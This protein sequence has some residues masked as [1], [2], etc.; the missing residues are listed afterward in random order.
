MCDNLSYVFMF[1]SI[2]TSNMVATVKEGHA[3]E[4]DYC[5]TGEE[6]YCKREKLSNG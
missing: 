1:L 3:E 6:D 4:E 5:N 2:A